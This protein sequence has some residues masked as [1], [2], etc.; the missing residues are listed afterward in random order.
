MRDVDYLRPE[1]VAEASALLAE[2]GEG[3]RLIAGGTALL[4]AL[5]QRMVAPTHLVSLARVGGLR[6]ITYDPRDGLRIGA[7]TTHSALARSAVVRAHYPVLA[8]MA[9]RLADP[10]VRN[11]GTLGGNLCYADPTTDPP[12]CLAALDARLVLG[13]ARGDR[14]LPVTEFLVDYFTTALHPDE[15]LTGIRLPPPRFDLGHHARFHRTAAEHRPLINLT[16]LARRDGD[17]VAE[18]RLV[19]GATTVVPTRVAAAEA[20]L[21]G[22]AVTAAVAREAADIV[23]DAVEPLSDL[24]GTAAFRRDMLRVMARRS[25]ERLMPPGMEGREVA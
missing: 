17:T 13:S 23:A 15:I 24:R 1:T 4:L 8:D 20:F 19:V 5:R 7:L 22:R 25:I 21:A 18:A 14:S 6:G 16:L 11:Q 2:L 10:Q 12:T 9:G 3:G